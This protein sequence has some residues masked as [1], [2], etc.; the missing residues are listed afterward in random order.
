M[1][2]RAGGSSSPSTSSRSCSP[3]AATRTSG[4]R[5][6]T[7]WWLRRATRAG[8]ALVLVAIRADFYGRCAAYPELARLLAANHVLV[9][10]MRRDELRRAIELPARRAGLDV[11]PELSTRSSPAS[12]ASPGRCPCCRRR[13]S[14]C[15]RTATDARCG[16][17]TTRRRW[18]GRAPSPGSPSARTRG[19]T[20]GSGRWPGRSCCGSRARGRARRSSGGASRSPSSA[21]DGADVLGCSPTSGSSRIG[22]G[23][24]EVAHEALLREWPRLRVVARGGRRGP[25]PAGH[26]AHAARDWDA[27]GRDPPSCTGRA[28]GLGAGLGRRARARAHHARARR[29]STRAGRP[30]SAS[31]SA[32]GRSTAACA[33]CSGGGRAAGHLGR[34]RARRG[35][36]ARRGARRGADRRRA[37]PRLRRRHPRQLDDLDAPRPRGLDLDDSCP[38]RST[39]LSTL[40]RSPATGHLPGPAGRCTPRR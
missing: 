25:A 30:A 15:G 27:A 1:P 39:L 35:L 14:S 23:E 18:R 12:R 34:R 36:A 17:P 19:S 10:P 5:S 13:C 33:C 40:M 32:S 28:A 4:R 38:T 9:G 8:R 37:A 22:E 31:A 24:A 16:W 26:L 7:R 11:E 3:R 6:R 21:T 20:R 29:S 2:T